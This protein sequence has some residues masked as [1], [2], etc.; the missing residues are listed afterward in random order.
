[1]SAFCQRRFSIPPPADGGE[2]AGDPRSLAPNNWIEGSGVTFNKK[3]QERGG[4]GG[5]PAADPRSG[6]GRDT[7]HKD[8][9]RVNQGGNRNEW[10]RA[11]RE[12]EEK[13]GRNLVS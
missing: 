5:Q 10:A 7:N 3:V 11:K 6:W 12:Q 2:A 13:Q 9:F 4:R 1:M 8:L